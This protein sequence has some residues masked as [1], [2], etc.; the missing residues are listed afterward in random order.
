MVGQAQA[1]IGDAHLLAARLG[2]DAGAL[3]GVVAHLCGVAR[4]GHGEGG[5]GQQPQGVVGQGFGVAAIAR[6][7]ASQLAAGR[8]CAVIG[9]GH[10][11]CG[12]DGLATAAWG[13]RFAAHTLQI[14]FITQRGR[15]ATGVGLRHQLTLAV[16]GV[17]PTAHV[18]IVHAYLV[19][20]QVIGQGCDAEAV[21]LLNAGQVADD[22]V[23]LGDETFLVVPPSVPLVGADKLEVA[24]TVQ[25]VA[26]QHAVDGVAQAGDSPLA[27]GPSG[28]GVR[29]LLA[30][31]RGAAQR[32]AQGVI[33]RGGLA[34]AEIGW[35]AQVG[36]QARVVVHQTGNRRIS[37]FL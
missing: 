16:I 22:I 11:G 29:C 32:A 9:I 20:G 8:H 7:D 24:Q 30:V 3:I 25:V 12:S 33:G 13:E 36:G 31:G 5:A 17:A 37:V 1:V 26:F 4:P 2:R 27:G 14:R 6:G 35:T 34:L 10:V 21:G 28:I 23:R 19:A 18:H 15:V